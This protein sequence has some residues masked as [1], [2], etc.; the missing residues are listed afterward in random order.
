[1]SFI[2][3]AGYAIVS[4]DPNTIPELQENHSIKKAI[5]ED[6]REWNFVS[7]NLP[8]N[9]WELKVSHLESVNEG[10]NFGWRIFGRDTTNYGF[11]GDN[12]VDLSNSTLP[13]GSNG[14]VGDN[15][16]CTGFN[17]RSGGFGAFST[18][19]RSLSNG[20]CSV[21][22]GFLNNSAANYTV[23]F[24]RQNN[25]LGESSSGNGYLNTIFGTNAHAVGFNN[26]IESTAPFG[27]AAGRL[28]MV[29][30][31]SATALGFNLKAESLG[32][33]AVGMYSTE[34]TPAGINSFVGSDKIFNVGNGF[35]PSDLSDAFTVFKNASL[36]IKPVDLSTV[37][38]GS[39]GMLMVDSSDN[40][41]LK[42]HDGTDWNEVS[43]IAPSS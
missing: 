2:K 24:G 42:F 38:N 11:I 28:N 25:V 33:T 22:G 1:M 20:I 30:G 4:S 19:D 39:A 14:A 18:G 10:G 8:L 9:K 16:F 7:S 43:L 34:Y 31:S 36:K 29:R 41:K 40:N 5:H 37:T 15:S 3:N 17:T 26:Q 21:S 32:E 23:S 13:F 27:I 12:A 35:S 6:G